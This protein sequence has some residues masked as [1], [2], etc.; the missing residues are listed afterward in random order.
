MIKCKN[1]NLFSIL[2]F[3][4]LLDNSLHAKAYKSLVV[5]L[6][7][8]SVARESFLGVDINLGGDSSL[9]FHWGKLFEGEDLRKREM[10]E[11]PYGSLKTRGQELGFYFQRFSNGQQLSGLHWGLG[12]GYKTL[13]ATWTKL[14]SEQEGVYL[15]DDMNSYVNHNINL[16]GATIQSRFGYRYVADSVGFAAGI[17]LKL[18]HF[19]SKIIDEENMISEQIIPI[20]QSDSIRLKR[21]MMTSLLPGFELGWASFFC[22][23]VR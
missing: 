15:K 13:V 6:P 22:H 19:Q 10:E 12:A 14:P 21:R 8:I 17:Y 4:L 16:S 9:E 18:R 1:L 20:N 2:I 23:W 5:T 3:L 11:E 7:A